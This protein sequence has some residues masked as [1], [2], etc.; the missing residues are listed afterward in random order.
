MINPFTIGRR[1]RKMQE[2][3]D[4]Y[5]RR[6][7]QLEDLLDTYEYVEESDIMFTLER[8]DNDRSH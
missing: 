1:L 6:V 5:R 7:Q 2:T 8:G 4:F 3:I